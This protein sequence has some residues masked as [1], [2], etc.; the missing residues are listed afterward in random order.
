[1]ALR[2]WFPI[3]LSTLIGI[4]IMAST[5]RASGMLPSGGDV[6]CHVVPAHE[7]TSA[8]KAYLA[9]NASQAES[10][11]REALGK[12]PHDATLTAG[13]VRSLLREQKVDDATSAVATELATAPNSV[14]LLTASAEVQYRQGKIAQAF[15]TVNEASAPA[16]FVST[17]C[18]PQ[19]GATSPQPT[20]S[21]RQTWIFAGRGSALCRSRSAS[22]NKSNFWR[23][24]MEWTLKNER[25]RKRGFPI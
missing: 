3:C 19:N 15:A 10:L 21:I 5:A 2:R 8:E 1:M 22:I 11:Y 4:A 17:R 12:T 24:L 9:G 25:V 7:P 14:P 6:H 23:Q 13:L 20:L 16:F 18:M